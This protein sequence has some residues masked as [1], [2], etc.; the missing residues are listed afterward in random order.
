M[1]KRVFVNL[2]VIVPE[3]VDPEIAAEA[4]FDH[5]CD[6]DYEVEQTDEAGDVVVGDDGPVMIS[7]VQSIDGF[8]FNVDAS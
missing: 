3:G 1:T 7:L 2:E 5:A 4:V 6:Y 8:D